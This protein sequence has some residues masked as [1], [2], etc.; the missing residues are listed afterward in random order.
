ML[1]F[2]GLV[3]LV[4]FI[5]VNAADTPAPQQLPGEHSTLTTQDGSIRDDKL[6][7]YVASQV[8]KDASGNPQV[9][10]VKIMFNSCYGGGMLD[11]FERVFGPGGACEGVPWVGGTASKPDECAW[12]HSDESVNAKPGKNLGS[13]WTDA[14]HPGIRD[15]GN[16]LDGFNNAAQTDAAGP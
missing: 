6:A 10:D 5:A 11:D 14:L 9:K 2:V 12:G 3:A 15:G 4:G 7:D 16:V 13:C 1:V 8:P